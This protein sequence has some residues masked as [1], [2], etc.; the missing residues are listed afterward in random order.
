MEPRYYWRGRTP[1]YGIAHEIYFPAGFTEK[2]CQEMYEKQVR[3]IDD[4][5]QKKIRDAQWKRDEPYARSKL[6][7]YK[8]KA[9]DELKK[10]V[11]QRQANNN[12]RF[13]GGYTGPAI[14]DHKAEVDRIKVFEE[15]RMLQIEKDFDGSRE[16]LERILP[17]ARRDDKEYEEQVRRNQ[18]MSGGGGSLHPRV[19]GAAGRHA[20]AHGGGFNHPGVYAG[21]VFW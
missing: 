13:M 12:S 17:I 19:G 10:E 3:A 15:Q 14:A 5:E 20:A 7:K 6:F 9:I 2:Q 4:L 1:K 16:C 8:Q 21:G 18:M 11:Q